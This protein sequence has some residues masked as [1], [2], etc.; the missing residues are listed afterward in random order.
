M[1]QRLASVPPLPRNLKP[2][3][4]ELDGNWIVQELRSSA[5]SNVPTFKM[6]VPA[7]RFNVPLA[8]LLAAAIFALIAAAV[9]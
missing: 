3:V 6:L 8:L 5:A 1:L 7:P 4:V 9:M 2:P